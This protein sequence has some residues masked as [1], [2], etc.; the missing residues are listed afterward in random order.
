MSSGG[1][2]EVSELINENKSLENELSLPGFWNNKE[3]AQKTV[4]R[5]SEIKNIIAPFEK[6]Q[7]ELNEYVEF[8]ELLSLSEDE[9]ELLDFVNELKNFEKKLFQMELKS[10]LNGKTDHCD[11]VVSVNAG[12][13][14]T[15]SCDWASMIIRMLQRWAESQKFKIEMVDILQGEEAGIKNCTFIVKGKNAFGY[16]KSEIG[17][18]RLV[19]I[20]PFDSNK[21]RHTSFVSVDVTAVLEDDIEVDVKEEDL[22]WDTF[23]S[24]GAGGQHVNTTDSAVRV[25]HIPT[26]I[27]VSC[28]VDRSQHKNRAT[29]LSILKARIYDKLEKERIEEQSK[30]YGEKQEI[31]WGSQIRSYVF[32]PYQMVKDHRT[33]AET[34]NVDAVMD[35]DIDLFIE[36]YL[37][38]K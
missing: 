35:G 6:V 9:S 23:R 19:R 21:R 29:A 7:K 30:E 16:L 32:T 15:E 34:S 28:Q 12:A 37:K 4:S 17:V 24:S 8:Y 14:G 3:N 38:W 11:A 5:I 26:G 33:K 18:H 36:E 27:I 10:K 2:F 20:S 25:T 22:K 13:G 31:G 1:F